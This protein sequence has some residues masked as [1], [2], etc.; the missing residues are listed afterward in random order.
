MS[1]FEYTYCLVRYVHN[2]AA[3][4]MLNIGVLLFSEEVKQIVSKFG[5]SKTDRQ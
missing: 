5:G 1:R 3:G 2:P 4:E